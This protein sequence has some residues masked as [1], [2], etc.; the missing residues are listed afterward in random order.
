M[1]V[2]RYL[3]RFCFKLH[4]PND[5]DVGSVFWHL[6]GKPIIISLN[7]T[8]S[9]PSRCFTRGFPGSAGQSQM[10][11]AALRLARLDGTDT[12]IVVFLRVSPNSLLTRQGYRER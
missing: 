3:I 2:Q 4:K 7:G 6:D 8:V 10:G 1:K 12:H 9:F 11:Y 5:A